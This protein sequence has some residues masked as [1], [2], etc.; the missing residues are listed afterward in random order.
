M[1]KNKAYTVPV[2]SSHEPFFSRYKPPNPKYPYFAKAISFSFTV[3][4]QVLYHKYI[5]KKN[6]PFLVS[7]GEYFEFLKKLK[8]SQFLAILGEFLKNHFLM[9]F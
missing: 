1:P 9:L 5:D 3:I 6:F 4:L 2:I 7:L 8:I